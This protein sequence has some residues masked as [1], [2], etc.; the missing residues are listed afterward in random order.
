MANT[1]E[2]PEWVYDAVVEFNR[3]AKGRESEIGYMISRWLA[4]VGDQ[5]AAMK[6]VLPGERGET[7]F[8]RNERRK[9]V[10]QWEIEHP[11]PEDVVVCRAVARLVAATNAV[12]SKMPVERAEELGWKCV[13][14]RLQTLAEKVAWE[15]LFP[16]SPEEWPTW[17]L[18]VEASLALVRCKWGIPPPADGPAGADAVQILAKLAEVHASVLENK[19]ITERLPGAI[20]IVDNDVKSMQKDVRGV[21]Q[22]LEDLEQAKRVPE[23]ATRELFTRIQNVLTLEDQRIWAAVRNAGTQKAAI[24]PLRQDNVVLSEATLS[25]RVKVIDEKLKK[26][27]LSPCKASGPLRRFTKSGGYENE[28]GEMVPEE[29]SPVD[30]D[31]TKDA[32]DRDRTIQSYLTARPEDK[33][34]FRETYFGIEDEAKQYVERHPMKSD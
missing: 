30:S 32:A 23:D 14:P 5:L 8:V 12:M 11:I 26:H 34:R 27:G 19:E 13:D 17:K 6:A 20:A 29:F 16:S 33:E 9:F 10:T 3:L 31:W 24:A 15:L 18:D 7:W 1:Q 25:R 28:E 4:S 22:V 2:V 21:P